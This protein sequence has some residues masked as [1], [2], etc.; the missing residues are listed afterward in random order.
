MSKEISEL[1]IPDECVINSWRIFSSLDT[2]NDK[3]DEKCE[4][5]DD[6]SDSEG[7]FMQIR[8][9]LTNYRFI[10]ESGDYVNS[11]PLTKI[12]R[13]IHCPKGLADEDWLSYGDGNY[14]VVVVCPDV[15]TAFWFDT[16]KLSY[17]FYNEI[18]RIVLEAQKQL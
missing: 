1:L 12:D 16:E 4:S 6:A 14:S 15:D 10:Y 8:L 5:E 7:I 3:D 13:I 18:T 2:P 11:V 9:I 17:D